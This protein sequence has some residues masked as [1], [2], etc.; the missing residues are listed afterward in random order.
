MVIPRFALCALVLAFGVDAAADNKPDYYW[1]AG[2]SLPEATQE[3]YPAV[4]N[5]EIFVAGGLARTDQNIKVLDNVFVLKD[6][7]WQSTTKLPK[8]RHHGILASAHNK[9]WL[10]GG[11]VS[12]KRGQWTNSDSV[13]MLDQKKGQWISKTPMPNPISETAAVSLNNKI[14]VIGG[15]SPAGE[16]NGLWHDHKDVGWHGVYNPESD[17]WK[18]AASLPIPRN[19]ACAVTYKQNIHVIG[20][21]QVNGDN[22]DTHSV[23]DVATDSWSSAE[24]LPQA[25][26]GL[27]CVVYRHS[28]FVFGGEHFIDEGGVFAQV[29]RY[30]LQKKNWQQ[31]SVMP[32]PRH[33]LGAVT[34]H[35]KIWLIGG[36]SEAGANKT[37]TVVSQL[38]SMK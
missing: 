27:A 11:F 6:D 38:T 7:V 25:Q 35:N 18:T 33:G 17:I 20:G 13:M 32:V 21:R 14:H 28:I 34:Y 4:L 10:F 8:P 2:P 36:A 29:W 9:L 5:D 15:R 16:Q 31:V 12:S 26:A 22:L 24:P 3:I 1:S 23:F 30:D 37:S 19:S